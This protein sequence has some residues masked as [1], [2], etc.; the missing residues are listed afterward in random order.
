MW[1]RERMRLMENL[2]RCDVEHLARLPVLVWPSDWSLDESLYC[3]WPPSFATDAWTLEGVGR[4]RT[5][6][7]EWGV[8]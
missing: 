3:P 1:P 5:R 8:T 7:T 4:P 2:N 6:L